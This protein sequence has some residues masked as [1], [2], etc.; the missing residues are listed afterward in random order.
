MSGPVEDF[1]E[2]DQPIPGQNYVCLSFVSPEKILKRKEL[3]VAKNFV[4][5]FLKQLKKD[6]DPYLL[7]PSKFTPEFIDKLNVGQMFD[8]YV[9]ANEERLNQDYSRENDYHTTVRGVK[10]RGVYDT[11]REAEVRSKVLAR[12]DPNHN[13]FIGQVG[14]WLAWDPNPDNVQSQQYANDQLNELV[15][16]Y[17]ENREL[18]DQLYN[19]EIERRKK[20]MQ[21]E[22]RKRK[23]EVNVKQKDSEEDSKEKIDKLRKILDDKDK[24]LEEI[25]KSSQKKETS[26][27]DK[28]SDPWMQRKIEQN[29]GQQ[30][31]ESTENTDNIS[32]SGL[33]GEQDKS[34]NLEDIVKEIF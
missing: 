10:I 21:E 29:Q 14:F 33:M 11:Y 22:N 15:K 28:Y 23:E 12:K 2:A 19:D 24:Y 30:S 8:D 16:R 25:M 3:F 9:Y 32:S 7:D 5:Y 26:E 31:S 17:N 1:L 13:V 20:R 18:K 34:V 4:D 6:N 27:G